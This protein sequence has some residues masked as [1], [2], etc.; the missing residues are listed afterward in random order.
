MKKTFSRAFSLLLVL[1]LLVSVIPSAL[2]VD[3]DSSPNV[4]G[5]GE[6]LS[7]TAAAP[8]DQVANLK[9]SSSNVQVATVTGDGNTGTVSGV[10]AGTATITAKVEAADT[11]DTPGTDGDTS[12]ETPAE[13]YS[14]SFTVNVIS[15]ATSI[16][17]QPSTLEL[18][19]DET[20]T[21][22]ATINSGSNDTITWADD[23]KGI[24]SVNESGLVTALK[25]GTATITAYSGDR[26]VSDTCTVT[27]SRKDITPTATPVETLY[28][29]GTATP[30]LEG[31]PSDKSDYTVNWS[32]KSGSEYVSVTNGVVT[33]LKA[34]DATLLATV[35][36]TDSGKEKYNLIKPEIEVPVK[37]VKASGV[38][39]EDISVKAG[40]TGTITLSLSD[41]SAINAKYTVTSASGSPSYTQSGDGN[42]IIILTTNSK[43]TDDVYTFNVKATYDTA[44]QKGVE[45]TGSV[46]AYVYRD[47]NEIKMTVTGSFAS[48][49][50]TNVTSSS[51]NGD[52]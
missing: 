21:L 11:G 19:V 28:V 16:D 48:G 33:A 47:D 8:D 26:S 50:L 6:S 18:K 24:A 17:V 29:G 5:V 49:S 9:W 12:G 1:A 31:L 30:S 34:G 32:V 37:V 44:T 27:V 51:K 40:Q 4:V 42:K 23:G 43:D 39:A 15:Y 13:P 35:K 45:A 38:V 46:K 14:V 20:T 52:K 7:L 41:K 25:E 22:T 36:L 3:G 10:S 2:A